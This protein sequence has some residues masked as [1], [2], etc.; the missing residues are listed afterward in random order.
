VVRRTRPLLYGTI[1]LVSLL[2][3]P[4]TFGFFLWIG[5][6]VV[7]IAATIGAL[8][9]AGP[10]QDRAVVAV[11]CGLALLTGPAVYLLLAL[12]P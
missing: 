5:V 3:V 12:A 8:T 1:T 4:I 6:L 9:H 10:R 11:C 7:A 2:T